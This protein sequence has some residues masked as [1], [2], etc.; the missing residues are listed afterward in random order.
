LQSNDELQEF[1]SLVGDASPSRGKRNQGEV[2]APAPTTSQPLS[3]VGGSDDVQW[4]LLGNDTYT[5]CGKTCDILPSQVYG[6]DIDGRTGQFLFVIKSI[7]TDELIVLPDTASE[8]I[9]KAIDTFWGAREAFKR[10]G[11]LFKR[12]IMMWGPPGGGKTATLMLLSHDIIKRGGIVVLANNPYRAAKGLEIIR[13]VE[14]ERPLIC[15]LE[16]IDEM[17]A[18]HGE[19]EI[20]ALLDGETQIDNVAF[21]ATTNYP[22][23][24]DKRLVNR[25]SRF[26]EIIK[27]GMPSA[28]ARSVY[29]KSRLKDDPRIEQW[30]GD[31]EGFSVAH[32]R[33]LVVAVCCLGRTYQET[34]D[35]L[36]SMA[37]TPKSDS[38]NKSAGFMEQ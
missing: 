30:V 35:R 2:E 23:R 21:I 24:L 15:V 38:G 1:Q 37:R 27:V 4:T 16:D 31:T 6:I 17:V 11:Q 7:I 9:L 29:L 22:E 26:D 18:E 34:I 14:P 33:E 13:R 25:P 12:G 8:R 20:L 3:N 19:H 10:Y 5:A 36:R 32:L 28:A